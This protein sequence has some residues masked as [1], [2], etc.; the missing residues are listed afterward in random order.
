MMQ[1]MERRSRL[2]A[3]LLGS[4]LISQTSLAAEHARLEE[5]IVTAQHRETFLQE[6][7]LAITA[8]TAATIESRGLA[9]VTQIG[10]AVPN[11]T[12][13]HATSG[14]GASAVAFIRGVGQTDFNFAYEPGVGMYVDDVYHGVL[15]GSIFDLLDLD[16]IE[17]LRGPQGTLAGRNSIGGAIK[18]YSRKPSGDNRGFLEATYGDFNRFDLRGAYDVALIEDQVYLRVSGV[19][20]QRDGHITRYDY[21]C[22]NPNALIPTFTSHPDCKI[23]TEGG[24][25]MAALRTSLRWLVSEDI[26]LNVTLDRTED[27]SQVPGSTL[28]YADNPTVTLGGVPVPYDS[29]F[30]PSDPYASFANYSDYDTGMTIEPKSTLH[31]WG[32]SAALDWSVGDNLVLKYIAA[33]RDYDGQFSNDQD[34]SPISGSLTYNDVDHEQQT[35]ELRLSGRT[36]NA[37]LD[38][39][40]GGYYYDAKSRIAGRILIAPALDFLDDDPVTASSQSLFAHSVWHATDKLNLSAGLRYT[41]DEKDYTFTRTDP[42]SG[43]PAAIV[44]ILSGVTGSFEGEQTDYRF[45]VDYQWTENL[46]TYLQFATGYKG[47]GINPRPFIPAQVVPFDP[48]TLNAYEI[49]VKADLANNTLRLNVSAFLNKYEDIILINTAGFAGFPISAVPFNAGDA[50]VQGIEVELDYRPVAELHV[51]AAVGILDFEYRS[52]SAQALASNISIDNTN[53]FTPEMQWSLGTEYRFTL[54][55]GSSLSPRVDVSFRD[56][57]FT[58]ADN[59]A[60]SE[61]DS[62]TLANARLTW[63]SR[64]ESWSAAVFVSNLTDELYHFNSFDLSDVNGIVQRQIGRPREWGMTLRRNF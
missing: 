13:N 14:L 54:P 43:G 41:E 53:V 24:Q 12:I 44:G 15:F 8:I 32:A 4:C 23:G 29:R 45:A 37:A 21:T 56:R 47:G 26:E 63:L 35:H 64:D 6:T 49:G 39:T 22:R 17:V 27:D 9:D 57:I 16:R 10:S 59:R 20:K 62:Y 50:D 40:L 46:M 5:I 7:P 28:F 51:N 38:W 52:L 34:A 61:L 48:E 2:T 11:L 25:D 3:M 55:G 30:I 31:G 60:L 18:L 1:C 33:V 42:A 36:F 58:Q 19:S